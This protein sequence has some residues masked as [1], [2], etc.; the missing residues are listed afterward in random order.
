MNKK[1][2][3][4]NK[5][6]VIAALSLTVTLMLSATVYAWFTNQRRLKTMTRINSPSSLSIGAGAKE[7][8]ANIDMGG[9]DVTDA[10]GK[11]DFVFCVFSDETVGNYKIQLAHTTNID[12]TYKIYK[13]VES[14][15][16]LINDD[17]IVYVDESKASHYYIKDSKELNGSYLNLNEGDSK[18]ADGSLHE[19]S[20]DEYGFVQKNAEPL[21]WQNTDPIE[22]TE[23]GASFVDYYILEVSWDSASVSNDKETDMVYLTAGMV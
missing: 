6:L 10:A 12:F 1:R 22:H 20:Y 3:L 17:I 9:I 5:P 8:S 18:T 15:T 16:P 13:A 23:A 14:D 2:K 4:N 11:K 7:D 21:Y 19:K